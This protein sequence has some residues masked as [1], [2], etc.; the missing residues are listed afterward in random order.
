[1]AIAIV[2]ILVLPRKYVVA[3]VLLTLFLFPQGQ[4]IVLAGVHLNAYRIIILFGL[5]RWLISAR[6]SPLVGGFNF[7]DRLCT[8][9][10]LSYFVINSLLYNLQSQA[11][12]K[13]SGDL[14]DG[15]GC[16]ILIRFLIRDREDI[17]RTIKVLAAVALASALSMLYEQRTGAN[18]FALLGGMPL[19]VTRDGKVRSQ[20][21]FSVFITAGSFGAALVPLLIWLWSQGRSK[22]ITVLGILASTVMTVTCFASTTLAAYAAG[23]GALCLWPIRKHMRIVRWGIVV[24]LVGLHLVM[25]GPVWSIIEHIDLT[26]SSSSYHR[27]MLI[28]NLIRHFRDWWLLGTTDN[29][30]W[31][32]DMWDTSNQYV[33]Y[34]FTGGLLALAL[35]IWIIARGFSRLGNARKLA[36]GNRSQEWFVWCLGASLFSHVIGFFGVKYFDQMQFAWF[37]LLAIISVAVFEVTGSVVPQVQE[38]LA[39]S[40]DVP[41]SS[42]RNMQVVKQ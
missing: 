33:S 19:E 40:Y 11:L 9:F 30:N 12:I 36:E 4:V 21:A 10:F 24:M 6:S 16:Y 31:G 42:S 26:G 18:P 28:D 7:M 23:V 38:D 1:M 3:P 8:F 20:A 35:F 13:N 15:L 27:Y 2:M 25:H 39:P 34:A 5:A 17:Q 22:M 32:F 37:V 41:A 29:P 14:L